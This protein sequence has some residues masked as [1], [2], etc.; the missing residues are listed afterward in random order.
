MRLNRL[1]TKQA[2]QEAARR[3]WKIESNQ[4]G[5]QRIEIGDAVIYSGSPYAALE[6]SI[7]A[8]RKKVSRFRLV[9]RHPQV[10]GEVVVGDFEDTYQAS[11]RAS[12]LD[13]DEKLYEIRE[14]EVEEE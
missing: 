5:V 6:L 9:I 14:V 13:L 7:P 1:D 8:A 10:P 12:E 3:G 4:N 11:N 2:E